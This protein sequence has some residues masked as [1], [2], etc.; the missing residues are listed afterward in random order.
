MLTLCSS[1]GQSCPS[2][3]ITQI[4][5][6]HKLWALHLDPFLET[7][8]EVVSSLLC[9]SCLELLGVFRRVC[10]QLADLSPSLATLIAR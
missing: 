9:S 5:R 7:V 10:A 2:S 4:S 6:L 8:S 1:L 3:D